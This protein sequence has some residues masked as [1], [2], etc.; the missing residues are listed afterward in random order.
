MALNVQECQKNA[1][2]K[3]LLLQ[4]APSGG[5]EDP[6]RGGG[7]GMSGWGGPSTEGVTWK[8]VI[9]D[10]FCQDVLAPL[11]KVG[12]LR[13][14]GVTLHLPLH[15]ERSAVPEVPS[16]Y[17]VEPTPQNIQRII[18]DCQ[19]N[20]YERYHLNF[21]SSIPRP[22]LETLAQGVLQAN[23]VHQITRVVDRFLSFVSLSPSQFSLNL[24]NAYRTLH[25]AT[26]QDHEI[27]AFID[28]V[29]EGLF[30]VLATLGVVPVIRC[31]PNDA[32]E[33]VARKLEAR[34]REFLSQRGSSASS[35]FASSS[36]S[37]QRPVLIILDRDI[38]LSVMIQHTWTYQALI[39]DVFEFKLN[40]VTVPVYEGGASEGDG[41]PKQKTY[42][43]DSSDAFWSQYAGVAFPAVATA[44][45]EALNEYNRRMQEIQSGQASSASSAMPN[46]NPELPMEEDLTAGLASAINALPEMTEKKR[47][48][49]MHTNLATA[50][51]NEI[52]AREL[53]KYYEFEDEVPG[54]SLTSLVSQMEA[55][56]KHST[57]G[58]L[59]D[60]TRALLVLYL[61]RQNIPKQ[62]LS[63]LSDALTAAGA[64]T[65]ALDYL[66][67]LASIKSMQMEVKTL[68]GQTAGTSLG[69]AAAK[70]AVSAL[71]GL[72]AKVT[73][74]GRGLLKGVK[75]FLPQKKDLPITRIVEAILEQKPSSP[76]DH[77]LY[78][79]PKAMQV[80]GEAP[81][82]RTPFKQALVFVVGGGNFVEAHALQELVL[83]SQKQVVYGCTDFV[84]PCQFVTELSDLGSGRQG[85][86]PPA[87]L[88]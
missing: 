8:I 52:K 70:T 38:D 28:R 72:A 27:E 64:S 31:P 63:A 5:M 78:L 32:A 7:G 13:R 57:R 60:K 73:D 46:G 6:L 79:D 87:D 44:I 25:D 77:Y 84:A 88:L 1:V 3:M 18:A 42:D 10:R 68:P 48:V 54:G 2:T 20:L 12:G 16:V 51:V 39:H 86:S 40:R 75:A 15:S 65:A 74:H 56:I 11:M 41:P 33:M 19:R 14:H 24:T 82:M 35:I 58:T 22:L 61:L 21:S 76:T 36:A 69:G 80:G 30:S 45:H 85:A 4:V 43:L 9:Y 49:D 37:L 62:Q 83:K 47:S 34:L 17:F 67:N 66:Q 55:F 53:D 50:L 81:R 29:V 59:V 71:G 23:S 26:I